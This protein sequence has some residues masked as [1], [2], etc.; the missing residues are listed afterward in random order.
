MKKCLLF[1]LFSQISLV[2]AQNNIRKINIDINTYR[3]QF[4]NSPHEN[5]IG[6]GKTLQS[7]NIISLPFPDGTSADFQIIEYSILPEG[8]N[9]DI[10]TYY[11]QKVGDGSINCRISLTKNWMVATVYTKEGIIVIERSKQA[12]NTNEYDVYLQSQNE[13]ECKAENTINS[14]GK[15]RSI[16]GILNYTNGASRR[17]YR[18]ALFVTDEFYTTR[19]GTDALINAELAAIVNN[20]NGLYEQE[21]AV[22]FTLVTYPSSSN[23]FYRKTEA[24]GTYDQNI[25]IIRVEMNTRYGAGN[26]DLGHCL[27]STGGGVAYY[28][29]CNDTY[30]GGGWS[31]STTPSSVLLMGHEVGHQFSAPHTFL[32]NGS[33]SCSNSNRSLLTALEPGSGNTIMSYASLCAAGQNIT[34][35]KVPYFHTNSLQNM[36]TYIQAGGTGN[37]CGTAAATGNTPPVAV[38]GAAFTIPKNTPFTLIGSGSDANGD[39]L[40]YTWEEYDVPVANDVG[41]LGSSTNGVGGYAAINSTTAPLFRSR[42]SSSPQRV[43]PSLNGILNNANNPA[44]TEGEDLP[45]V[46]RTMNFRLTVRDNRA[47]GGG[48]H[49]SALVVTVDATKGPLAVTLPNGGET[50]TAGNN[51]TINWDVNSTN[52]LSANVD[53]YLSVDGGNTFPYLIVSNTPNDGTVNY[54]VSANIA[55]TTQARI[56]VVSKG[57]STANF[58]D[59]SNTNFTLTST[60]Q[61][62][63][64]LICPDATLSAQSGNASLNLGLSFTPVSKFT[65]SSRAFSTDGAGSFPVINYTNNTYTVCQASSWGNSD[66]VLVKFRV[67]LT[68]TYTISSSG[69]GFAVYSIFSSATYNCNNFVGGNS[70]GAISTN[71]S[72]S[73]SLN[74][75]TTYYALLYNINETNT[76]ITFGVQGTGDVYEVLTTPAGYSYTYVALNTSTS[77]V[78]AES[79]TSNFTSLPAGTFEVYGVMYKNGVVPSSF[80]GQSLS[81]ILAANCLLYSDNKKILNISPNPCASL[82]TLVN[83]AD[84]IS[85]GNVTKQAAASNGAITA[86]NFV[87]GAGTRATYQAKKIQLNAGFKADNGTI[88][89]AEVGGCN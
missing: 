47:G 55:N 2:F 56:K 36:I 76:S 88:F 4:I 5:T 14:N 28:G 54:L 61:P 69:D 41:A 75:C 73:I 57:S 12:I 3:N 7:P 84:N 49:C 68:G 27:H 60:C 39:V 77:T 86:T 21:I 72:R 89:K 23:V 79:A 31:G 30:K 35:G 51:Q 24:I 87:T 16:D 44:D 13:F 20:L 37:T 42:Q 66:A 34:G 59:I 52:T 15:L 67:S 62:I 70:N 6:T 85:A 22:R 19:G 83:P 46:S 64:S 1:V 63:S 58:F 18:M 45:N 53:I 74:S 8:T 71:G 32:G 29:V 48:T 50:W 65:G 26:Y 9:T 81:A 25:D 33:S 43:F 82:L 40:T 38:A 78:S 80:V 10:K 11:G 17:T